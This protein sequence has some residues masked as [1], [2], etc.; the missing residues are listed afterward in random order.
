MSSLLTS[1]GTLKTSAIKPSQFSTLFNKSYS[2]KSKVLIPDSIKTKLNPVKIEK[3]LKV[4]G[5]KK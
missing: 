3:N 2:I 4:L 1:V 5:K